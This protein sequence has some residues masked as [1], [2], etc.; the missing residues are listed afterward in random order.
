M[1]HTNS[2]QQTFLSFHSVF[3]EKFNIQ[4]TFNQTTVVLAIYDY[5]T[6]SLGFLEAAALLL[7]GFR[8][9]L[10]LV[11]NKIKKN[12]VAMCLRWLTCAINFEF[13]KCK[14]TVCFLFEMNS[15]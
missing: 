11:I 5:I 1:T 7:F 2:T 14:D 4:F 15:I 6:C 3:S 9:C 13:I 8:I 10:D 12:R